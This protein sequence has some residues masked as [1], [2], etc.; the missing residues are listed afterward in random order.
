MN[1]EKKIFKHSITVDKRE[2]MV[3]TG[4]IDVISFDEEMIIT[5]TEMGV[6][7][8]KGE[9]LHVNKINLEKG[10]LEVDGLICSIVYEEKGSN[11][12]KGGSFLSKLLK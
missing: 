2:N 4:V 10:D 12:V 9:N 11:N 7:I 3:V 6:L 1:E 8:I 5:E